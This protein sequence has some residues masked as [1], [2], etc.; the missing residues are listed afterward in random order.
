MIQSYKKQIY[1]HV[2]EI[3]SSYVFTEKNNNTFLKSTNL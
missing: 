2:S 1:K 3:Y